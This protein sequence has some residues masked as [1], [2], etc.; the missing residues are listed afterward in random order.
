LTTQFQEA[1]EAFARLL[2]SDLIDKKLHD[3][4]I[5]SYAAAS[6]KLSECLA[7]SDESFHVVE[8]VAAS[9]I[10]LAVS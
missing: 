3:Q 10:F 8:I 9:S 1:E 2:K 6:H 4:A 5:G 7:H